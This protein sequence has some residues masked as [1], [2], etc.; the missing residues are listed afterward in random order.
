MKDGDA[1][2][3]WTSGAIR[4]V[5]IDILHHL[6]RCSFKVWLMIKYV[7]I[8]SHELLVN[9]QLYYDIGIDE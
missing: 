2:E 9:S 4:E 1:D 7:I 8:K 5:K 6:P 3:T